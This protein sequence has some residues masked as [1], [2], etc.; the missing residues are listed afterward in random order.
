MK[1]SYFLLIAIAF[2]ISA[3]KTVPLTGRKGL[4][5]LSSSE[6]NAMSFQQYDEVIGSSRLSTNQ[7]QTRMVKDC[8]V[9]IQGA[10]EKY[11]NDNGY[12]ALLEGY[13]WEFNLIESEDANAWCMPGGKVAFY[14]GILPVCKDETGIAVVMGHEVAHA[15]AEHGNERMSQGMLT[16]LGG[17]ALSVAMEE[18]PD[19]TKALAYAAFGLGSQYGILLPYSRKHESEADRLGLIFMAMAGYNPKEAVNFWKRMSESGGMQPPEF[20]STHPSHTTRI[21]NLNEWMPEAMKYYRP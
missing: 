3:C 15:I 13:D 2:L 16:Q 18:Q 19:Q 1:R 5:L 8:G 17:V 10:V 7:Q 4:K 9:K 11:L 20:M 6:V 12:G 21:E 14:T